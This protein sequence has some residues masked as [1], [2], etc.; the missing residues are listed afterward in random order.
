MK[1]LWRLGARIGL[2]I[3]LSWGLYFLWTRIYRFLWQRKYRGHVDKRN[4]LEEL[5]EVIRNREWKKDG[6]RELGD[7]ISYPRY[8][9]EVGSKSKLANDCD[10]FSIWCLDA[11]RK[12]IMSDGLKWMPEGLMS[13]VWKDGWKLSGHNVAV[14]KAYDGDAV[15]IAHMSNWRNGHLYIMKNSTYEGVALDVVKT[16]DKSLVGWRLTS[17]DLKK[18]IA[19]RIYV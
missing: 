14:F 16:K 19:C 11:A 10:D 15:K 2:V 5:R 3:S 12:T 6:W 4:A 13:I 1:T 8:F 18:K 9:E 7:A 17:P